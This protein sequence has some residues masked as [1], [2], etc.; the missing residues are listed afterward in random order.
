MRRTIRA[1]D[2]V[3]LAQGLTSGRFD[4]DSKLVSPTPN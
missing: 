1:S 3:D 2:N 4:A